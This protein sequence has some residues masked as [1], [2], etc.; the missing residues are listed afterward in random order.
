M[1]NEGWKYKWMKVLLVTVWT[2]VISTFS[3]AQG[4]NTG[5]NGSDGAL[6]YSNKPA[7]TYIFDPSK[8]NPPLNPSGDNIFNFTTINIPNGITVRLSGRIL[9]GPVFWLATGDV[10]IDG[11]IDLNG[12]KGASE[13]FNLAIRSRDMPGAG[14]YSGGIG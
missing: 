13:T 9:R 3:V 6:D 14:A 10:R 7:G 12:Q 5:S 2:I 8:F 11:V 1:S 4:F